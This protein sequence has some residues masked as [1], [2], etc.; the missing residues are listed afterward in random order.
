MISLN[1]CIGSGIYVR[2]RAIKGIGFSSALLAVALAVVSIAMGV[3]QCLVVMLSIWPI[4]SGLM[5]FIEEFVDKEFGVIV[6]WAY[7]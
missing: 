6:G 1:A 5:T 7:W 3:I 2:T 4:P